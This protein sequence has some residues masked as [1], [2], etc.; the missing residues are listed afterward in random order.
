MTRLKEFVQ[1]YEN[2]YTQ[3]SLEQAIKHFEV[4]YEAT[5]YDIFKE[6]LGQLKKKVHR[7]VGFNSCTDCI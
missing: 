7:H 2:Y 4:A 3:E 1:I 5:K 6:W